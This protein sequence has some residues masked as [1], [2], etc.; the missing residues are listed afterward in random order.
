MSHPSDWPAMP[1]AGGSPGRRVQYAA[2]PYRVRR[3]G[4]VQIRLI[5]SR[6]T[7]RWVLP[8]GWPMKG[9]SPPKAAARECYEEAGLMGVI[10]REPFG[11]YTYEKRLGTRSVLCDVL[12]FPLKVKRHLQKWPERFQRHGFWFSVDSAAGAVQEEDLC[13]LIRAFG[14]VMARRWEAKLQAAADKPRKE[15]P[16][17]EKPVKEKAAKEKAVKDKAAKEKVAGEKA[18]AGEAP[19]ASE[20]GVPRGKAQKPA[21]AKSAKGRKAPPL[22]VE[23][24]SDPGLPAEVDD[25]RVAAE[26][27]ARGA[28][29]KLAKASRKLAAAAGPDTAAGR[30]SP[31]APAEEPARKPPSAKKA[32]ARKAV[33]VSAAGKA[34]SRKQA[35]RAP[36]AA[37][38]SV[39]AAAVKAASAKPTSAKPTSAK[40]TSTKA[41]SASSPPAK[42]PTTKAPRRASPKKTPSGGRKSG[43]A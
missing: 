38:A 36:K 19:G 31:L 21:K 4:E 7:R 23:A 41:P 43:P 25:R 17:S 28:G 9:L 40:P 29:G 14:D 39:K 27:M 20:E 37:A 24:E 12:V 34:A 32:V 1:I 5:T 26:A 3:D 30:G 16:A 35:S 22:P 8:K 11:M 33:K 10:A 13:L 18:A 15:K 2:L 6:E 42:K